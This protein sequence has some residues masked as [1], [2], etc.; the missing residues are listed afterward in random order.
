M[1]WEGFSEAVDV[2]YAGT[3]EECGHASEN[4]AGI[5]FVFF[6][7]PADKA[8]GE[9]EESDSEPI[10]VVLKKLPTQVIK[11]YLDEIDE[12][13]RDEEKDKDFEGGFERFLAV[14]D[15]KNG[16]KDPPF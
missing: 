10:W 15:D 1:I 13:L 12:G 14:D 5:P 8:G 3:S 4:K 16:W 9:G 6:H 2:A 11:R 7:V